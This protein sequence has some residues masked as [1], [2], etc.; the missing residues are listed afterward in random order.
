MKFSNFLFPDCRDPERDGIVIDETLREA[1]L[2]DELGVDVIWLAE[3]HFDGI[4]AYADPIS[5]AGALATSTRHSKIGFAVVQTALH[6]PIRLAEQLAIFDNVTK[7][8]LVVG[9]G[10]GSSY[11]IYDYQGFGIDH[12]EAQER[13]EEAE[14]ILVEAWTGGGFTHHGKFWDLDVPM[15]RPRPYT[16]PHPVIIR[17]ASGEPSML[18]LA[19]QGR[20]F[21]MNVQSMAVTRQRMELYRG[22]MRQSGYGE[23][24]IAGNLENCW[25]WRNVFVAET[26]AEAER[27]GVPVFQAMVESRAALRDRI[28]RETGMRIAVPAGDL[29]SARASVEHG[30]IHGSPARV[31]EA[32]AEIDELGIGGVIASFRLGP[33]PHEAAA[34]SLRLSCARLRRSFAASDLQPFCSRP[35]EAQASGSLHEGFA[36]S[37][38]RRPDRSRLSNLWYPVAGK[39]GFEQHDRARRSGVCRRPQLVQTRSELFRGRTDQARLWGIPS[40]ALR[41]LK[42]CWSGRFSWRLRRL[43]K[44][45]RLHRRS[46]EPLWP[47][48]SS[49]AWAQSRSTSKPWP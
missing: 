4:C 21:L 46:R 1:W 32:I 36:V 34:N 20:P 12:H 39:E 47:A 19:R 10:R 17:A 2:S 38:R 14:E 9:L 42:W 41:C 37:R 45:L 48:Q 24:R 7:G 3:H 6:H 5:F 33:M 16:K 13:L 40:C 18:E 44:T 35:L 29:P 43:H 22:T 11:N 31:A 28:F 49:L 8:R 15:L 25:V 26:D 27:V 30:F 23:D